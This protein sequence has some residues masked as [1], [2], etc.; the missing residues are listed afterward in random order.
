MTET[1]VTLQMRQ[2]TIGNGD[3]CHL[4]LGHEFWLNPGTEKGSQG[5]AMGTAYHALLQAEAHL[6]RDGEVYDAENVAV[7][8][9]WHEVETA[10][11]DFFWLDGWD[12]DRC[13]ET[14]IEG[15]EIY[16]DQHAPW[17]ED[18]EI[19]EIEWSFTN[20][21]RT[22]TLADGRTVEWVAHGTADL[23][24]IGRLDGYLYLIDHK[25]PRTLWREGK[26][27]PRQNPQMA[28]YIP[29]VKRWW[30]EKG[31]GVERPVVP[32]YDVLAWGAKVPFS[33]RRFYPVVNPT[34]IEMTR[35]KAEGYARL[36]EQGPNGLFMPNTLHYL[37]H[38]EYC[39]HWYHC[40][41]G[42]KFQ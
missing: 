15:A 32:R 5:R 19:L 1:P 31:D 39:D 33:Y 42:E 3:V 20:P 4:R 40:D 11:D 12:A 41:Y 17:L 7:M 28:W 35:R 2:S 22:A 21:W 38:H 29:Q 24:L 6:I 10:R 30:A 26:D 8:A 36:I 25:F 14:V 23:I 18:Y 34:H 16:C 27:K 13:L 9:F 37:C